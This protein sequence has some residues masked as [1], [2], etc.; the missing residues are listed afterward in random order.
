VRRRRYD[1][2][3]TSID[4]CHCAFRNGERHR[5]LA[6]ALGED[7]LYFLETDLLSLHQHSHNP[8]EYFAVKPQG[9]PRQRVPLLQ[10]LVIH[11]PQCF[12]VAHNGH[13]ADAVFRLK[14]ARRQR[15]SGLVVGHAPPIFRAHVGDRLA[16]AE[17]LFGHGRAKSH[18][19][20]RAVSKM[21]TR[22]RIYKARRERNRSCL[23]SHWS[24]QRA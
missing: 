8:V 5:Q 10:R 9:L 17:C 13:P 15:M 20:S 22:E 18:A 11:V 4:G 7:R 16:Q 12:T 14:H 24:F 21:G 23:V 1:A 2:R 3:V 6:P 19:G